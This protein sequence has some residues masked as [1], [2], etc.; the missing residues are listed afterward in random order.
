MNEWQPDICYTVDVAECDGE[1]HLL[2]INSFS[3]AGFYLNDIRLIVEYATKAA[4]DEWRDYL[5]P[6]SKKGCLNV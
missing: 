3:C 2:E 4:M 6:R 5:D 1:M